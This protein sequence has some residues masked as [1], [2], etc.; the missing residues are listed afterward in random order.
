MTWY[1][2]F[3]RSLFFKLVSLN[4]FNLKSVLLLINLNIKFLILIFD[5]KELLQKLSF[6]LRI[7]LY[8]AYITLHITDFHI[9]SPHAFE[10][11]NV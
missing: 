7:Y 8:I 10:S 9:L 6:L 4:I 3:F 2:Y 5:K 1:Y 11:W